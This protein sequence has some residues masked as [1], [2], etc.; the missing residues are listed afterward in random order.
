MRDCCTIDGTHHIPECLFFDPWCDGTDED[1]DALMQ[2]IEE[3]DAMTSGARDMQPLPLTTTVTTA[4]GYKYSYVSKRSCWHSQDRY[5][6]SDGTEV[7][8]TALYDRGSRPTPD[9]G[10]YLDGGWKP[11]CRAYHIGWDDFGLP[12]ADMPVLHE[13]GLEALTIA[14]D[15]GIVEIGCVG[16]HGRTGTFLA[17]MDALSVTDPE[18]SQEIIRRVRKEYC[19]KAIETP[20]QEWYVQAF[21]SFL[22]GEEIKPYVP[23]YVPAKSTAKKGGTTAKKKIGKK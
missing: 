19:H 22:L 20:R 12:R 9:L 14:A 15:G 2:R 7:F 10:I 18:R 8:A 5:V 21:R 1:I 16:A 11:S 3:G 17:C 6:L 13:I 4:S 23:T